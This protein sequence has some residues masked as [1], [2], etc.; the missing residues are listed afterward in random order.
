MKTFNEQERQDIKTRLVAAGKRSFGEKGVKGTGIQDLAREAGIATGSFYA[1]YESKE[2]LFF[3]ILMA[4]YEANDDAFARLSGMEGAPASTIKAM[5]KGA[6]SAFRADPLM[7][8]MIDPDDRILLK[9]KLPAKDWQSLEAA[10]NGRMEGFVADWQ[11]RGLIV[12]GNPKTI[13]L[14]LTCH[15]FIDRHAE[16][17]GLDEVDNVIELFV[18]TVAQG[19]TERRH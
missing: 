4:K 7:K 3:D 19:L 6:L 15:F 14:L 9:R 17:I 2:R 1:F 10:S 13:A 16:E 5:M 18:Q 8:R 12:P 11:S